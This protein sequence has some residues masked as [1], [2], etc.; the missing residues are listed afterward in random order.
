MEWVLCKVPGFG[1]S[2][3]YPVKES[4]IAGDEGQALRGRGVHWHGPERRYGAT[5]GPS[6]IS[7]L[8]SMH[9]NV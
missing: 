2:G 7:G 8:I 1:T 9:P 6:A 5:G 4:D 3:W